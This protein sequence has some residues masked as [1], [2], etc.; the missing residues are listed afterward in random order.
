VPTRITF[1]NGSHVL[2][3]LTQSD[4]VQAVR[5]DHPHPVLLESEAGRALYVNWSHV[6]TLDE[7]EAAFERL[8]AT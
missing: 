6:L 1:I 2:V 4:V 5:R 8:E 7:P 3:P